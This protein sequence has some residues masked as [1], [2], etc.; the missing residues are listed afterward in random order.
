MSN[1]GLMNGSKVVREIRPTPEHRVEV[2][3]SGVVRVIGEMDA[4]TG[5]QA[6]AIAYALMSAGAMI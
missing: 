2:L 4:L 3:S 6:R 5:L 1:E